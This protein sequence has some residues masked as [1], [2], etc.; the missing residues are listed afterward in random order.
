MLYIFFKKMTPRGS[1]Y[2]LNKSGPRI[3][4]FGM[5]QVWG[6]QE[7]R[8]EVV[9]GYK[10]LNISKSTMDFLNLHKPKVFLWFS[11]PPDTNILKICGQT[12]KDQPRNLTKLKSF[13]RKNDWKSVKQDKRL[14]AAT[15]CDTSQKGCY[16]VP[17]V[18]PNFCCSRFFFSVNL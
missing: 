18:H 3:D 12:S 2:K 6:N 13:V 15:S 11:Q 7:V 14:L 9:N 17:T 10:H 4:P 1:R 8:W 5:P 16:W